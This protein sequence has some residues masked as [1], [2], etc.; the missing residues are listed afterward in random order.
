SLAIRDGKIIYSSRVDPHLISGCEVALDVD[1]DS[2]KLLAN[3]QT[4]YLRRALGLG[5]HSILAPLF[6]ETGVMP[7]AYRRLQLALG[8]LQYLLSLPTAHYAGAAL[9]DSIALASA[10]KPCWFNDLRIVLRRSC[11]DLR[12]SWESLRN[13]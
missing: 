8:F 6:T 7:I 5:A 9:R 1:R 10:S 2:L 12:N 13:T 11:P 3:C 4:S